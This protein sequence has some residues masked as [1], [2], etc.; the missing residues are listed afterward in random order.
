MKTNMSYILQGTRIQGV[1][2]DAIAPYVVFHRKRSRGERGHQLV[3]RI[4]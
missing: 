2:F 4:R 1:P 3:S